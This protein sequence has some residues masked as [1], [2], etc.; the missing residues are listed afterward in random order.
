MNNNILKTTSKIICIITSLCALALS[1]YRSYESISWYKDY[2]HACELN[3]QRN[4]LAPLFSPF[5]LWIGGGKIDLLVK[6]FY[7]LLFINITLIVI[8]KLA[9]SPKQEYKKIFILSGSVA[10]FPIINLLCL[11]L[12]IPAIKPDSVYDI[13]YNVISTNHFCNTFYNH[14]LLYCLIYFLAFF[15]FCGLTGGLSFLFAKAF[16]NILFSVVP[17]FLLFVLFFEDKFE[18]IKYRINPITIFQ[19]DVTF[20]EFIYSIIIEAIII[21]LFSLLLFFICTKNKINVK[22]GE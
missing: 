15:V 19:S 4:S 21:I 10:L 14:P 17:V 11:F 16:K 20:M 1:L 2:S 8:Y 7:I 13:H 9:S 22:E 12:F 5:T 3:T 6:M 18:I